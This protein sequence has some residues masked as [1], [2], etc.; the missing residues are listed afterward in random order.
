M[1]QKGPKGLLPV[2]SCLVLA[3]VCHLLAPLLLYLGE[4]A[5]Y[6]VALGRLHPESI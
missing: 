1:L 3:H 2:A 5:D 6:R 4:R